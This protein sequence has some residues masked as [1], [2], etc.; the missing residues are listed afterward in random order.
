MPATNFTPIQLYRTNTASTTAPSAGNLNA[1]ELAINYNDGGMILF[2]KNTTGNVIKLMNNPA[3]LLYPTADGTPGQFISTNGSGTLSFTTGVSLATPLA[4]IGNAAGGAEIRLPEDTDNGSNYVAL[5]AADN[6]ASNLTFTLPSVDGTNGQVLQTNGSGTLSFTSQTSL[7]TPLAVV[8]NSSAG[9]EIRLPEDTDNGSN[10]VALKAADNLASNLTLTLPS[11]DGTN[12]QFLQTNGS[13]VLSF[14]SSVSGALTNNTRQAVTSSASTT[15]DLANGNVIDLTMAANITTLSFT[16]VPASGTP[17]L[18]QIVVINASTGTSYSIVWPN[19]VYWSAAGSGSVQVAPTLATGAN[20]VT[21]IALLTTDGGTKYRGWVEASIPGSLGNQLFTWGSNTY[22]V[23]GQNNYGAGGANKRSS[24]VQV[25]ALTNWASASPSLTTNSCIAIKTDGTLW[26]W[27]YNNHGQIGDNTTIARSSPV[28]VGA[29]TTWVSAAINTHAIALKSDGTL[30]AWGRGHVGQC[31]QNNVT[32]FSS[33]VQ[34]GALTTWASVSAGNETSFAIK[35]DGTLWAWG[36]NN[37]YGQL[38]I[39]SLISMSSPVQVGAL[40]TWASVSGGQN[41]AIARRTNGTIYAW[42][43]NNQGQIGDNTRITR[44]SPV[45]IG[46]LTTWASVSSG[47]SMQGAIKTDG[48]LW[49]WGQGTDGR[50]GTNDAVSRSSPVQ[51]GALTNWSSISVGLETCV[52]K[53][54]DGTLWAWGTNQSGQVGQND[55]VSR[56]SPVQVGALSNW[57]IARTGSL[58]IAAATSAAVNPA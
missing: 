48:T 25:G 13:G 12:G 23:L 43:Y 30:W 56:S 22:G 42:G 1:G 16:N 40:T 21:V 45:Q 24:P 47:E 31:G 38:G 6:L 3:N 11:V 57:N 32:Y 9:A 49:M 26:T 54:T 46:A 4:V 34:V 52:A 50:L 37:T 39:N 2:A 8:G 14:A 55:V 51:I 29:L 7:A 15:I 27:G 36:R 53:K 10:Y 19:T 17:I 28:Q 18:I 20:G 33:P 35:T 5:K 58:M 44:S 41:I